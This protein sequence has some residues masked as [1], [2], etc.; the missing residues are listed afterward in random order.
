MSAHSAGAYNATLLVMVNVIKG[1][2][3]APP[4]PHQPGQNFTLMTESTPES[5]GC[6]QL[7]VLCGLHHGWFPQP[8][9]YFLIIK[10][11]AYSET[12]NNLWNKITTVDYK[13]LANIFMWGV[14]S[15]EG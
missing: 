12:F 7:C 8:L 3:R 4:H 6:M 13:R 2:G 9:K 10:F 11:M 14:L 15:S 1:D 5:S